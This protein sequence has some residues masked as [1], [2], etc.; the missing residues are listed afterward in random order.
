MLRQCINPNANQGHNGGGRGKKKR[1]RRE[2][3]KTVGGARKDASHAMFGGK[4]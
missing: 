1:P 4:H 3:G 2:E